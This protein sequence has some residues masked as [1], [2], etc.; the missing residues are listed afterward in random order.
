MNRADAVA[1]AEAVDARIFRLVYQDNMQIEALQ[2][3]GLFVPLGH[4]GWWM[5][6]QQLD[7]AERAVG[8]LE[9]RRKRA[10]ITVDDIAAYFERAKSQ[11]GWV[12]LESAQREL[13]S[14]NTHL[15]IAE[16]LDPARDVLV[17]REYLYTG[18]GDCIFRSN[19]YSETDDMKARI[20]RATGV[21]SETLHMHGCAAARDANCTRNV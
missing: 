4:R 12:R 7:A 8:W 14:Q 11:M 15:R 16:I 13:P 2:A 6:H 20:D 10:V 18:D 9:C 19:V 1:R 3:R 17:V 5:V 21:V